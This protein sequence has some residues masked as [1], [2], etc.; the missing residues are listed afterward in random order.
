[1]PEGFER[2]WNVTFSVAGQYPTAHPAVQR[3]WAE[4][5]SDL[6]GDTDDPP[7]CLVC[8]RGNPVVR[9]RPQKIKGI[10]G[11]QSSGTALISTNENAFE[12]YGLDDMSC[13]PVCIE[14]AE[15]TSKALNKLL[16]TTTSHVRV[17]PLVYAYW[18]RDGGAGNVGMFLSDPD[19]Q[20]V[21][22]LLRAA[23]T[24]QVG[25]L[26]IPGEQFYC[27]G[28]GPSGGRAAVR[29]WLDTSVERVERNLAR[30]F[31]L[32]TLVEPWG[33]DEARYFGVWRLARGTLR[34]NA[35]AT[36]SPDPNVP[37]ALLRCALQGGPL[38]DW[39]LAQ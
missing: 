19:P 21:A 6:T 4:Y 18:S 8:G 35:K 17:N 14:C 11:G 20:E 33:S 1:M 12:S 26:G 24:G 32:M 30:Y 15:A 10:P 36:D 37:R 2:G 23:E 25:A 27:V 16:A 22:V 39:L 34:S 3:F 38:P 9:I 28:L 31:R 7:A 13:A 5:V 29:D